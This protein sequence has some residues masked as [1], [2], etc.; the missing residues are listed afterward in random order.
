LSYPEK[1]EGIVLVGTAEWSLTANAKQHKKVREII[2]KE[3]HSATGST[4]EK[5]D[6]ILKKI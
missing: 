3:S 5:L 2:V 6:N 4:K 1:G